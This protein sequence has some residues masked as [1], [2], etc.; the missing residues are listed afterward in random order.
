MRNVVPHLYD[1]SWKL[2]VGCEQ[3]PLEAIR[4]NAELPEALGCI[5]RALTTRPA[6]TKTNS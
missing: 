4:S 2:P 3:S 1:G 5:P 6:G